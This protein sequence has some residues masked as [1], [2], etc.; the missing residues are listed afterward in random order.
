MARALPAAPT[1]APRRPS[2]VEP[3]GP[4]Q[5]DPREQQPEQH[6]WQQ[7]GN[8]PGNSAC[9]RRA[10]SP[11]ASI[12]PS[13]IEVGRLEALLNL[14]GELVL[15]KNRLAAIARQA[16]SGTARNVETLAE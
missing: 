13:A 9:R 12:R 7:P 10:S 2:P 1:G 5:R 11:P 6:A 3:A 15:Q 4:R 14:V 8:S 16:A